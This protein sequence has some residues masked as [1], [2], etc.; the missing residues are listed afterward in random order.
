MLEKDA[1]ALWEREFQTAINH[2]HFDPMAKLYEDPCGY[3]ILVDVPGYD[4]ESL[5][6]SYEEETVKVSGVCLTCLFHDQPSPAEEHPGFSKTFQFKDQIR[7]AEIRNRFEQGIL[8]VW[9]PKV[10]SDTLS[11][12]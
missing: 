6:V 3:R 11:D 12:A 10:R 2:Q 7:P 5:K 1:I 9:V 4:H 8:F